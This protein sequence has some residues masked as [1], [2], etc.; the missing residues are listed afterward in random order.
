[1]ATKRDLIEA[2][3]DFNDDEEIFISY[4][5]HDYWHSLLV[6]QINFIGYSPVEYSDY[7]DSNKIAQ[8]VDMNELEEFKKAIVIS[9]TE[10]VEY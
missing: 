4:P 9:S 1:M 10:L 7:F 3:K 8:P 5:A 2:L 6:K